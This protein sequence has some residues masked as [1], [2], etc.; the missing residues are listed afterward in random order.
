MP[1]TETTRTLGDMQ[2]TIING[3]DRSFAALTEALAAFDGTDS[4]AVD[5]ALQK[6]SDLVANQKHLV[7]LVSRLEAVEAANGDGD[8]SA[9]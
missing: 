3:L 2:A 8:V 6:M 1:F 5:E 9:G 7:M 4:T